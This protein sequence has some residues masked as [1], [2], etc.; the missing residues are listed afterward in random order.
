MF[1]KSQNIIN[2]SDCFSSIYFSDL[3][4]ALQIMA[5]HAGYKSADEAPE[6][7]FSDAENTSK[8]ILLKTA[9]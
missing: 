7:A 5:E 3:F 1:L 9:L 2:Y 4:S 6:N 8:K